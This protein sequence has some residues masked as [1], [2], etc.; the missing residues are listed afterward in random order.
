MRL[1]KK[2]ICFCISICLLYNC[3]GVWAAETGFKVNEIIVNESFVTIEAECNVGDVV[4]LRL[5]KNNTGLSKKDSTYAVIQTIAEDDTVVF[6]VEMPQERKGIAATGEYTA[7][8]KSGNSEVFSESFVYVSESDI[9]EYLEKLK[10]ADSKITGGSETEIRNSAVQEFV[11]CLTDSYTEQIKS[12]GIDLD[13]FNSLSPGVREETLYLIHMG[14]LQGKNVEDAK[15]LLKSAFGLSIYKDGDKEKAMEIYNSLY[16]A[17][18]IKGI[19]SYL[20]EE[21]ETAEEFSNAVEL[22]EEFYSINN[23]R[24]NT[25]LSI[26]QNFSQKKSIE[27]ELNNITGLSATKENKALEYVVIQCKNSP[28]TTISQLKTLLNDAYK[29]ADS[30]TGGGNGGSRSTVSIPVFGTNNDDTNNEQTSDLYFKDVTPNYWAYEYINYLFEK[31]IVS[32]NGEG[33]FSPDI[34]ITREEFVKMVIESCKIE[35]PENAET[36]FS[37][38]EKGSWYEKYIAAAVN[39]GVVTGVSK[40]YFGI[41]EN[42]TREDIA[43]ISSRTLE[44]SGKE[45][46]KL[47][48]YS[49]FDDETEIAQYALEGVKMLYEL[50]VING[51][52][53]G[54]FAPK[55][56][57]TRAE[58]AK[59]LYGILEGGK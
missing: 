29:S 12:L 15:K 18:Q 58:T 41:G 5:E 10:I 14:N 16:S 40:E 50:G 26:L 45:I 24:V 22:A 38:V 4:T 19:I 17:E 46:E 36:A 3:V 51:R 1:T 34:N 27:T 52:D 37:D 49:L 47:R 44:Y 20:N 57:A 59:I 35:I 2:V 39:A 54:K 21:Y 53:N 56:F 23:A 6:E 25:V 55:E 32:G 13:V 30:N 11:I 48:E 42:I 33:T 9:A 43:V 31:K 7:Y 28:V 8:L